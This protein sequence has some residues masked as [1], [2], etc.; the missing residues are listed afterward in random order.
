MRAPWVGIAA[1]SIYLR[2]TGYG[3]EGHIRPVAAAQLSAVGNGIEY[4]RGKPSTL[5]EWYINDERGLEQ[6]FVLV[7]P[8]S[9]ATAGEGGRGGEGLVLELALSGNLT[10]NLVN[11]LGA[12]IELT[13]TDRLSE[14]LSID[15]PAVV[16]E[17]CKRGVQLPVLVRF[18]DILRMQ[19]RRLNEAFVEAIADSGYANDFRGVYPI[20]V[21]QLHEVSQ[22]QHKQYL[23]AHGIEVKV[24]ETI[25][26]KGL[27]PQVV[28]WRGAELEPPMSLLG[29]KS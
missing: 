13:N 12:T 22:I 17:L 21:N 19:V 20:K 25:E 23:R 5:T 2:L 26:A 10:P 6:G 15:L 9:P 27:M 4:R 1:A 3:Y 28:C 8:P 16:A 24:W 18:Q 11:E 29:T 7:S 14:P